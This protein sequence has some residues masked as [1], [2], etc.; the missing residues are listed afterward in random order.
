MPIYRCYLLDRHNKIGA[1]EVIDSADDEAALA[2]AARL[3]NRK[4]L[5]FSGVEVWESKRLIGKV[6]S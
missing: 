6:P 2:A 5:L 3:L 4:R 1:H